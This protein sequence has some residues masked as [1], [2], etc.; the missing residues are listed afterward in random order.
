MAGLPGPSGNE[1]M[2]CY[3]SYCQT[4]TVN[5]TNPDHV[6]I[7]GIHLIR[8]TDGF[9]TNAQD[10]WIGGWQY[11]NHH[12]D[13]HWLV[14]RPGSSVVAYSGS[15]GGVHRTDDITAGSV[16]WS[17]LANGYNT[18]QF[19]AVAIDENLSGSNVVIGG[20]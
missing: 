9:A 17:S 19:Y 18:S 8:S 20:M 2:E 13:Q 5:P 3:S 16:T 6:Y 4:V 7:G 1:P 12:A 15:D 11:S 10:A 14:F